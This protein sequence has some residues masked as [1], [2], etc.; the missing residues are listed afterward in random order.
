MAVC[1]LAKNSET[2]YSV[3]AIDSE[4]DITSLPTIKTCGKTETEKLCTCCQ[5]SI[6]RCKDGTK[7]MLDGTGTWNKYE[8]SGSGGGSGVDFSVQA[9]DNEFIDSLF[10]L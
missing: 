5:G 7:Y 4:D 9:I 1:L 3:F 8:E 6:A 10:D 2:K